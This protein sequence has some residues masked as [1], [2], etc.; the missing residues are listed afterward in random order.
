MLLPQ[1][2]N[3]VL[4]GESSLFALNRFTSFCRIP[5]LRGVALLPT[6]PCFAGVLGVVFNIEDIDPNAVRLKGDE[7]T[8]FTTYRRFSECTT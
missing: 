4:R 5:E 2:P 6:R 1:S 7:Y 8:I 3:I